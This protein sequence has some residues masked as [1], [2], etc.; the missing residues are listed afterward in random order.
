MM[1]NKVAIVNYRNPWSS[2]HGYGKERYHLKKKTQNRNDMQ[3][4]K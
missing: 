4:F 3:P 2:N 1:E